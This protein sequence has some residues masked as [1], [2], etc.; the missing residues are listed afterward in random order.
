MSPIYIIYR[1]VTSGAFL[2]G[3]PPFLVFSCLSGRHQKGLRERIGLVPRALFQGEEGAPRIWIHAVSLGEVK[4]AI[5]VIGCLRA[6]VPGCFVSLS[7]TTDHG[8]SLAQ[9][10]LEGAPVFYAPVDVDFSVRRALSRVRPD[11]MVFM[12]TELWPAWITGAQ[13][14][15]ARTVV[16]NGR[17]SSRSIDRYVKFR[18]LF[19][20][21]LGKV[22]AFSMISAQDAD[23]I[24]RLG[25]EPGRVTVNGNSKYELLIQMANPAAEEE[26]RGLLNLRPFQKTFIAGSTSRGE[27]DFVLDAYKELMKTFPEMVL[28][29]APRHIKRTP[30]IEGLVRSK[31]LGYQLRTDLGRP[32]IKRT[33]P[34]V[35]M[36][37]FGELFK[38][39]SVGDIIFCGGSLIPAGGQNPLEAAVWGKVVFFGP[40][41]D[42]FMDAKAMLEGVGAGIMVSKPEDFQEKALWLLNHPDV[43]ERRGIRAREAIAR[44]QGAA[45]RHAEIVASMLTW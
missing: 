1:V 14:M 33:E 34:V 27:E 19:R 38:L 21:V 43:S 8:H 11:V 16:I 39:Y 4:A 3:F 41:M 20:E 45:Q 30:L 22:D 26:M 7:T 15:G 10:S 44:N 36:N 17:I 28:V 13:S 31:G 12:E 29:I 32:G 25:A 40:S 18:P 9:K 24:I 6:L 5:P 37:N 42:D 23:R 35:I 2:V